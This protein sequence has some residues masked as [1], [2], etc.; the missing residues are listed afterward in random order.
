MVKRVAFAAARA[1]HDLA[2]LVL[3][4]IL[5]AALAAAL[6]TSQPAGAAGD[7]PAAPA[8]ALPPIPEIV[9]PATV[10]PVP[11]PPVTTFKLENGLEVVIVERHDRPLAFVLLSVPAGTAHGD[12]DRP[13]VAE[14]TASMLTK[15]TRTRS[16][17]EIARTIESVGAQLSSS[18]DVE[19]ARIESAVLAHHVPLALELVADVVQNPTFPASELAILRQQAE[20]AIRQQFDDPGSLASLHADQLLYGDRH[21]LGH[22]PTVEEVQAVTPEDLA[23]F[24]RSRY[25][26]QG[27]RLLVA[28]EVDPQ[29]VAELVKR[30]FGQWTGGTAPASP[31]DP[32]GLDAT[33]IRFVEWPGQTQVRI[34]LRQP[35]PPAD[36]DDWLAISAYNYVLGGGGFASRLMDVVRARLGQTYDVHTFYEAY[37]FPAH[38]GLST[39]TRSDEVWTALEVIRAELRRFHD[40]GVTSEELDH[41][42]QF[43]ILGYPMMLETL[44]D[45]ALRI[46]SA[47][48][49]GRGLEWV[50][51]YPV[52]M[53]RLSVDEVNQAI[54][55]HFDP[56]RFAIVLLGDPKVLDEAPELVWGVPKSQIERVSRT[57]VPKP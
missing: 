11:L 51:E 52:R 13:G 53:A 25:G 7:R 26:P 55:R 35:G 9:L 2:G 10:E 34:E 18:A 38:F 17:V 49:L 14:L 48:G 6:V 8:V 41:A 33:R 15:G 12:P 54:R 31:S 43:F 42:R 20:A 45:V 22:F 27:S 37:S 44:A 1:R 46:D 21:P 24:H 16:A 3:L 32:P 28:G 5:A 19:A 23:S 29:Q 39:Y 47:L 36:V 40:E 57:E 56:E 4:A 30:L 50:S